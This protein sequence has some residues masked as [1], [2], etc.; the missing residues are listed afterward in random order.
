MKI[1]LYTQAG[2]K[3]GS[4]EV[5]DKMFKAPLNEELIRL[6]VVRQMA[7][8]RQANAH[9]KT[10]GEIRGGGRKPWRQK[11]TG[12]AR[13]GS[14]RSPLWR[15][16]GVAFGPRNVRNYSLSMPVQA[17]RQA[18]FSSLSQKTGD[19]N[20]FALDEFKVKAPKT[21]EF[22]AML[23]KLPAARTLLVVIA[24]KD[25]NLEKSAANIPNVKIIL[26]DYLNARDI[27]NHDKIMF[28]EPAIK[29]A[30]KLF[31]KK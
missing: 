22:A 1:D 30:E 26:A 18:L 23:K 7:N 11:G 5:S 13:Q 2:S 29:K 17:R 31:L 19:D 28:M 14:T 20:V 16:G 25:K 27:L 21:R 4:V 9:V 15:H 10:R 3:K 12:H 6:A 8:A 24:E